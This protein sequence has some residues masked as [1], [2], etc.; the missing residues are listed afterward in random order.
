VAND[1]DVD[2]C[3]LLSHSAQVGKGLAQL[4]LGER[5]AEQEFCGVSDGED[6]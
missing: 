4:W 6:K 1:H 2:V 5:G 3:F